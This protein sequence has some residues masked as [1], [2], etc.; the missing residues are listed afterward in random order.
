MA[1]TSKWQTWIADP[2]SNFKVQCILGFCSGLI[3]SPWS[4]G[5]IFFL[6]FLIV[7]EVLYAYATKM[8]P[9]QWGI[10]ER[11]IVIEIAILGWVIGRL[12]VGYTK[13]FSRRRKRIHF[14]KIF[15]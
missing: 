8:H 10:V 4:Y 15:Q 11:I 5:F 13:P 6:L 7:W 2:D 1:P 12:L 9:S 3:F 14:Q